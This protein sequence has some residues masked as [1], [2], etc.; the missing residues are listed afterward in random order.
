MLRYLVIALVLAAT[1]AAAQVADT[2]ADKRQQ[3]IRR[4][5]R[6]MAALDRLDRFCEDARAR[7]LESAMDPE[8]RK[9]FRDEVKDLDQ[10]LDQIFSSKRGRE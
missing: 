6:A 9:Q 1:S 3:E 2:H 4:Q 10:T 7:I 8:T 5:D